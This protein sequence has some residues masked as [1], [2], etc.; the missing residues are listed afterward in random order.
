LFGRFARGDERRTTTKKERKEE[1][2]G[3]EGTT[4]REEKRERSAEENGG[5]ERCALRALPACFVR[6]FRFVFLPRLVFV[7]RFAFH[8]SFH[9]FLFVLP[10]PFLPSF[11]FLFCAV[12]TCA[13]EKNKRANEPN[14]PRTNEQTNKK[15]KRRTEPN[16]TEPHA[17]MT[18][19]TSKRTNERREKKKKSEIRRRVCAFRCRVSVYVGFLREPRERVR[20]R[21]AEKNK[22]AN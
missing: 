18:T 10:P 13:A 5:G 19:T 4:K 3:G 17:T 16:Q 22:N 15:K 20:G 11:L 9:F 12:H 2:G 1:G 7:S 8:V 21:K 6:T 14:E